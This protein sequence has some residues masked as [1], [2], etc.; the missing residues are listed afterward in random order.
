MNPSPRGR[1]DCNG[2]MVR[3]SSHAEHFVRNHRRM[4]GLC[5]NRRRKTSAPPLATAFNLYVSPIR[6]WMIH[7]NRHHL[8]LCGHFS[9][10]GSAVIDSP[11]CAATNH[12]CLH[13]T[14]RGAG[15]LRIGRGIRHGAGVW[16]RSRGHY[17][18]PVSTGPRHET[19]RPVEQSAPINPGCPDQRS[20]ICCSRL[21]LEPP[22]W[23]QRDG[24][25]AHQRCVGFL[26]DD[27]WHQA[28]ANHCAAPPSPRRAHD[29]P[30]PV[31]GSPRH[32]C[33]G[34]DRE[35]GRRA[36]WRRGPF[37]AVTDTAPAGSVELAQCAD[38]AAESHQA[39]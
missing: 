26:F 35:R 13:R 16:S 7:G 12:H 24:C 18:A 34:H 14:R 37:A 4:N 20:G 36:T 1:R 29:R 39:F 11:L 15:S 10:R 31:S 23:V 32:Y 25:P 6:D 9:W 33:V 19:D 21:R 22:V 5:Q 3:F 28:P 8:Y 27:H 30:A 17:P 38:R 2:S